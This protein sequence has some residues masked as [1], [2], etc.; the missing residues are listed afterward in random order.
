MERKN[1]SV[2][3]CF[4][5]GKSPISGPNNSHLPS[6]NT[7]RQ[8]PLALLS[9]VEAG[10]G[11]RPDQTRPDQTS[12]VLAELMFWWRQTHTKTVQGKRIQWVARAK[13]TLGRVI[14]EGLKTCKALCNWESVLQSKNSKFKILEWAW[15]IQ[16]T[17]RLQCPSI[18]N[19]EK[20]K[21]KLKRRQG[22]ELRTGF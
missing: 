8:D 18:M 10:E 12:R 17:G 1:K 9:A 7:E 11:T 15:H 3:K 6:A 13:V 21:T 14:W 5:R 4:T 16:K 19:K 22:P 20:G 2:L